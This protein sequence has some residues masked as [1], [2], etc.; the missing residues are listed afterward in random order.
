MWS[1]GVPRRAR[2]RTAVVK[3]LAPGRPT[4][5]STVDIREVERTRGRGGRWRCVAGVARAPPSAPHAARRSPRRRAGDSRARRGAGVRVHRRR[6]RTSSR[7]RRRPSR[8]VVWCP[9]LRGRTRCE[10]RGCR[11]DAGPWCRPDPAAR[12]LSPYATIHTREEAGIDASPPPAAP[13]RPPRPSGTAHAAPGTGT[14]R[15]PS[16][17][18]LKPPRLTRWLVGAKMTGRWPTSG[19]AMRAPIPS[20]RDRA[21]PRAPERAATPPSPP[22]H[23]APLPLLLVNTVCQNQN[24]SVRKSQRFGD[25]SRPREPTRDRPRRA[26]FR[27]TASTYSR[28]GEIHARAVP[29]GALDTPAH[30]RTRRHTL[31]GPS[32]RGG[33][34]R[35]APHCHILRT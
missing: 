17:P 29:R 24:P 22:S 33:T 25:E 16:R 15:A 32:D 14:S 6:A 4:G 26:R 10:R 7:R 5:V 23:G 13:P 20:G 27:T 21:A 9:S 30:R 35:P 3:F 18:H 28:R 11:I 8:R 12:S 19:A 31:R 34:K 2:E 1:R